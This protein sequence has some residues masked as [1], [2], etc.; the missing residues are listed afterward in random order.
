MPFEAMNDVPNEKSLL[1]TNFT[2][3]TGG[4]NDSIIENRSALNQNTESLLPN[5]TLSNESAADNSTAADTTKLEV[6]IVNQGPP[7]VEH[8][9]WTIA[10]D[11]AANGESGGDEVG[12]ANQLRRL[13]ELA[14][15]TTD[16]DMTLVVSASILDDSWRES[17]MRTLDDQPEVRQYVIRDGQIYQISAEQSEGMKGDLGNLLEITGEY[18]P[19]NHLGLIIQSHGTGHLGISGDAGHMSTEEIRETVSNALQESELEQ[20][21]L[22]SFNACLMGDAAVLSTIA[23]VTDHVIASPEK[24]GACSDEADGQ[25]M[26]EVIDRAMEDPDLDPEELAKLFID[27]ARDGMNG[28]V[29]REN[30]S[31]ETE[32]CS[33]TFTLSHFDTSGED[34]LNEAINALG[35]ELTDALSSPENRETI[36]NDI[37]GSFL[38]PPGRMISQRDLGSFLDNLSDSIQVGEFSNDQ[39]SLLDSIATVKE[40]MDRTVV[41]YYGDSEDYDD[42]SG[43]SVYLP[44][45]GALQRLL[46]DSDDRYDEFLDRVIPE[47]FKDWRTFIDAYSNPQ[48][49]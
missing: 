4:D 43:I 8:S 18:A 19:S 10:I 6:P 13:M 27:V 38:F 44:E 35:R 12:A 45:A 21:D 7:P 40:A 48:N 23:D 32:S 3:I 2:E 15:Q 36:L 17:G 30:A 24:E 11:L 26:A 20:L 16:A 42:L 33:G 47:S 25:N 9:D 22:L 39:T 34:S 1:E 29:F 28:K 31:G 41:D 49:S 37:S 5:L 14:E 46:N